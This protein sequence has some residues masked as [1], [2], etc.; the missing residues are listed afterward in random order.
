MHERSLNDSTTL[1]Q[2]QSVKRGWPVGSGRVPDLLASID[3]VIEALG[4]YGG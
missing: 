3:V 2:I 4:R 1:G